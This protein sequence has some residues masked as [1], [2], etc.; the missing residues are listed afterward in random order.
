MKEV[1]CIFHRTWTSDLGAPYD[2]TPDDEKGAGAKDL[3]LR[4]DG[5]IKLTD[6]AGYFQKKDDVK[7]NRWQTQL[8]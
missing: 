2:L 3:I 1:Y 6:V 8:N 5:T 7:D 4:L